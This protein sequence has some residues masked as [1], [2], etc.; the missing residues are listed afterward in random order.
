MPG[1]TLTERYGPLHLIGKGSFS[2]VYRGFDRAQG[3]DVAIKAVEYRGGLER[4][5]RVEQEVTALNKLN[6]PRIVRVFEVIR[7]TTAACIVMELVAGESLSASMAR[8]GAFPPDQAVGLIM[9]IAEALI[10]VHEKGLIHRDLKPTNIMCGLEGDIKLLDFGLSWI[11]TVAD[12]MPSREIVGSLAY[13][14]PE[15]TGVLDIPVDTRADLYSLGVLF[16]ELLT[17][18]RPFFSSEAGALIHQ[19]IAKLPQPVHVLNPDIPPILNEIVSK[20][21]SKAP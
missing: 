19:H 5:L 20:L 2:T 18:S 15:Q 14:A 3:C 21:L 10:H 16:Y 4:L 12:R 1:L 8:S 9:K 7:E 11:M 13:M 17:A 6:H